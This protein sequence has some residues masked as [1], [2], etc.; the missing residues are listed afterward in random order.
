MPKQKK[1]PPLD[2][3]PLKLPASVPDGPVLIKGGAEAGERELKVS[4]A[5]QR[6]AVATVDAKP[7]HW[8]LESAVFGK[9]F[10]MQ[11]KPPVMLE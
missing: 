10:V 7:G 2:M 3:P 11:Q 8:I 1:R 5:P 6:A 4:A 9:K